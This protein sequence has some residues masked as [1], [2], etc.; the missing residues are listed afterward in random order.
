[1][2]DIFKYLLKSFVLLRDL[3]GYLIPGLVFFALLAPEKAWA[4]T[5]ADPGW[6]VLAAILLASYATAQLL[7]A[8]GYALLR[9]SPKKSSGKKEEL[10]QDEKGR[11]EAAER[12]AEIAH[13]KETYYYSTYYPDIFIETSRQDTVHLMRIATSMALV[14]AGL[15]QL[16][17]IAIAFAQNQQAVDLLSVLFWIVCVA[18]GVFLFVHIRRDDPHHRLTAAGA[19]EAA[20]LAEKLGRKPAE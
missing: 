15:A 8:L 1:M 6:T 18:A 20:R 5:N 13:L 7:A 9:W 10:T 11:A 2:A 3:I 14:L 16:F 4:L 17:L 19:L 12:A